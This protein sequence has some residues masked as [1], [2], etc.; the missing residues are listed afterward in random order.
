MNIDKFWELIEQCK[1]AEYP[2][3]ALMDLLGALSIEEVV[4]FDQHFTRMESYASREDIWGAAYL[5]NRGCGDDEFIDFIRGL[6]SKGRSVYE[7]ALKN[8]DSLQTLWGQG[9]I[10]NESFGWVA[11]KAYAKK[12]GVSTIEAIDA[13]FS[14]NDAAETPD[15]YI[16]GVLYEEPEVEPWDFEDEAENRK[17]LP[18]LSSLYYGIHSVS[19]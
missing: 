19:A 9:H 7:R 5:L 13:L 10:D 3:H 6:I 18:G 1:N 2:E 4:M 8:P 17:R 12:M 16:D 15:I 14:H 11:R